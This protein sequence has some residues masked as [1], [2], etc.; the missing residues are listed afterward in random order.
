[1]LKDLRT[2]FFV[3][4]DGKQLRERGAGLL[5]FQKLQITLLGKC[6]QAGFILQQ[7]RDENRSLRGYTH[8][9]YFAPKSA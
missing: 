2:P 6:A 3:V 5:W 8:P 1:M 4:A 7:M 9:R